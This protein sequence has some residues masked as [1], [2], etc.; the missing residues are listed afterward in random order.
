MLNSCL[1]AYMISSNLKAL[2]SQVSNSKR[3]DAETRE[4]LEKKPR[5]VGVYLKAK[6]NL[7]KSLKPWN[8]QKRVDML[9]MYL[10]LMEDFTC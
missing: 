4:E 5:D 2:I 7:P 8:D 10:D 1:G 6:E 3:V 9:K